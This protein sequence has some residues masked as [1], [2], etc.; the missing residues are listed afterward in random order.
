MKRTIVT[1]TRLASIF[2]LFIA[3]NAGAEQNAH[4]PAGPTLRLFGGDFS[5]ATITVRFDDALDGFL[6][7]LVDERGA[8]VFVAVE[9]VAAVRFVADATGDVFTTADANL[10]GIAD[11]TVFRGTLTYRIAGLYQCIRQEPFQPG[12]GSAYS[13][14]V[15]MVLYDQT[16]VRPGPQARYP[17]LALGPYSVGPAIPENSIVSRPCFVANPG[18]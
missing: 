13:G 14:R 12:Y 3:T 7:G 5:P 18:G 2:F 6:E 1:T 4:Q 17:S 11:F 10:D 8:P 15:E 9:D 16:I